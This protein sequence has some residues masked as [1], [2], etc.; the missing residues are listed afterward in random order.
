MSY[1]APRLEVTDLTVG[2]GGNIF[3]RDLSFRLQPGERL[4]INADVELA[5][6]LRLA[7]LDEHG[8]PLPGYGFD[9]A[10]PLHSDSTGLRAAWKSS[11]D[12]SALTGRQVRI[13]LQAQH[14][15]VFSLR[16]E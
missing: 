16:F 14:A 8:A 10:L 12:L 13:A 1:H 11:A 15:R 5:G 3:C 4:L 6:E 7:L 9:E 2:I